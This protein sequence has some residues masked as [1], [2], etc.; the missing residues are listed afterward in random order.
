MTSIVSRWKNI[1]VVASALAIVGCSKEPT[2]PAA[3]TPSRP[4]VEEVPSPSSISSPTR[5]ADEYRGF[6]APGGIAAEYRATFSE[7]QIRTIEEKR[8]ADA[9]TADYKFQGARL[10]KY[11]GAALGST[12]EIQLEFDL[13]GKVLVARAGDKDAS[14][15]EISAIRDRAQSLR[16]HAVAQFAV[17][18]HEQK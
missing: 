9:R 7:G 17:R 6:F 18:G 4:L 5:P 16:S 10:L 12:D 1:F 3:P 8:T 14:P 11:Q 13:Q 15:E 2:T